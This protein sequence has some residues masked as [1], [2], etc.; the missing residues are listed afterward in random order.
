MLTN[1]I[2]FGVFD[3]TFKVYKYAR[4]YREMCEWW[5]RTLEIQELNR[6]Q[7]SKDLFGSILDNPEDD[8]WDE[9]R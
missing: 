1:Q 6:Q 2:Q 8:V 3:S 4:I 7:E 9:L 5:R